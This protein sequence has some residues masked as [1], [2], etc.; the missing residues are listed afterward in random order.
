MT[1]Y[2]FFPRT[3]PPSGVPI[4]FS[5]IL[6]GA[7]AAL[8]GERAIELFRAEIRRY[9][10]VKHCF[11]ASSGRAALGMIFSALHMVN[12][13]RDEVLL[14]A[15]TSF[16]VPSA[17]VNAGLR[18]A[19][20]DL[21]PGTMSPDIASLRRGVSDRTLCLVVCHLYGYPCDMDAVL[22]AAREAGLPVV[23][24]AAQAMGAR[25]KGRQVGTFGSVGLFSLSRGKN[26][27][28]VDGGIIITDSDELAAALAGI[29]P[30]KAGKAEGL[31]MLIKALA[32]S[33]L[34]HPRCY[35]LPQR[36]PFLNI[37]ASV[38]DPGFTTSA[39]DSFRAGIASRML[40]RLEAIND[41]RKR[42][43]GLL[44]KRLAGC[45]AVAVPRLVDG[46]EP[47]FLR[48]PVL[49][50][51]GRKPARPAWGIVES[52]PAPLDEIEGLKAHL[53]RGERF[54]AAKKLSETILTLPT[55]QYVTRG[56]ALRIAEYL[57]E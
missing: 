49:C 13:D 14:P 10:E 32:L 23:D 53:A 52:Y 57:A 28:A 9:F 35:W 22:G 12:P 47:V 16:S 38:F 44:L 18:V 41:G 56:D 25:Y 29:R 6:A 43:A 48:L 30:G 51:K 54:P 46:A 4:T 19:L 42:K 11:L 3:L 15:Y 33:I 36:L 37:G 17:V 24:D 5:D 31:L 40:G 7:K 50:K 39:F 26:I 2:R 1:S 21:D 27:N 45:A 20:Y 8:R 55:N 34:L